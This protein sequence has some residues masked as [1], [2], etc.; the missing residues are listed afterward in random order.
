MQ[1]RVYT[2]PELPA[3]RLL[4]LV[5]S[6]LFTGL[7]LT[8]AQ[9][10]VVTGKADTAQ[11]RIGEQ[12]RY[13]ITVEADSTAQVIFPEGQTFSPLETVEA[14][15]TDTTRKADR[16][17]LQ[18]RYALTQFDSGTYLLPVQR[19]DV[20]GRGYL[21]DSLLV[22]VGG[23]RVDTTEQKLY[24]IKS[25]LRVESSLSR[26]WR[27]LITGLV[28]LLLLGGALYYYWRKSPL[29]KASK[30]A[31]LPPYDRAL[32]ELKRLETSKYLIHED[33]KGYYSDLT[34][35]LRAYL[36]EDAHIAALESTSGQLLER[37]ELLKDAGE[38]DLDAQTLAQ[39]RRVLETADLV[40]FARSRPENRLAEAD[41]DIVEQIVRKTHDAL[42]EPTEEELMEEEA[43]LAA[44]AERQ[45]RK[46]WQLAGFGLAAILVLGTAL[47][48][49]YY[50]WSTLR[51]EVF[52]TPTKDLL[53]SEWVRS[54]YGFPPITLESPEVLLRKEP[55]RLPDGV[56]EAQEF[57]YR[58]P[59]LPLQ[60]GA[61]SVT[62]QRES[63]EDLV[64]GLEQILRGW[65]ANGAKNLITK[66][67]EFTTPSGVKGL[68]IYG[69]G[70]FPNADGEE[71]RTKYA[72][73]LFVGQQF[74]QRVYLTWPEGDPY[75][76]EIAKRVLE[77]VD[78]K[79]A[80]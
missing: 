25:N 63:E 76:E 79:S 23:V 45:R 52:G 14:F 12:I 9:E 70:S 10:V 73:L 41:R 11:I 55:A 74:E 62:L 2:I 71:V 68:K 33:Y 67:E 48:I 80:V 59:E 3:L 37:M 22:Q 53:E 5:L 65:E 61:A 1:N 78:V 60:F 40:K 30:E 27:M 54:A 44:A 36:E 39:F 29:R 66:E 56:V 18:K 51:D 31:K 7:G 21:T 72:I 6:L 57:E 35:I 38:L 46:R 34:G 24:D 13:T 17:T 4:C 64:N 43:R 42:P 28:V 77:N 26:F 16:M 50:G 49:S 58:H 75:A 8:H 20:N 47:S 69:T 32:L 19:I 15:K